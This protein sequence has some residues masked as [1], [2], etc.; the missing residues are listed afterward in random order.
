MGRGVGLQGKTMSILPGALFLGCLAAIGAVPFALASTPDLS[1]LRPLLENHAYLDP[2]SVERL[3]AGQVVAQL[4][5]NRTDSEIAILGAAVIAVPRE[6]FLSQFRDIRH[7]KQSP[8][9]LHVG[10][11]GMPPT[12]SDL[13]NLTLNR[14]DIEA[15][16]KCQPGNC[17]LKLSAPMMKQIATGVDGSNT[18]SQQ[19]DSVF[20]AT[21]IDYVRRY[22]AGGNQALACYADKGPQVCVAKV[23]SELL[24]EFSLLQ[25]YAPVL[26]KYLAGSP[27]VPREGVESFL[28]WSEEK[29]GPLKPIVSVTQVTMYSKKQ[30]GV[31]WSFIASKQIYASHYFRASLGLTVLVDVGQNS[32]LM[33]YLNRSR[34]DGL[35][36][37]LGALKR[38]FVQHKLLVGMREH[39]TGLRAKL[40]RSYRDAKTGAF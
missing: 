12:V 24:G 17:G 36:G 8:E 18:S 3:Q 31:P 1:G 25:E 5:R 15:L 29:L 39:L 9:V 20:R 11:L 35:D 21:L 26:S 37:W 40:E 38:A 4:L 33:L 16:R 13:S 10:T 19:I 27:E 2:R 30:G 7:F 23:L 22:C 32:V 14:A 34:V 6:Y 28:Y